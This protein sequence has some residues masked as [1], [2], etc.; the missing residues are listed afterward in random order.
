MR[1]DEAQDALEQAKELKTRMGGQGRWYAVFGVGY[2]VMGCGLI[3]ALG[4]LPSPEA[5]PWT[6]GAFGVALALLLAYALTRPAQPRNLATLHLSMM[7]TWAGIYLVTLMVGFFIFPDTTAWWVSGAAVSCIPPLTV[8]Y[9]A[10][11]QSRSPR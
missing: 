11:R 1:R 2:A 5:L 4:L 3:L 9:V 6:M 8:A 7:S 10:L